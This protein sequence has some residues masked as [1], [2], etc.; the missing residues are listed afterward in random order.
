MRLA[1]RYRGAVRGYGGHTTLPS[2][3]MYRP[4]VLGG[5]VEGDSRVT[6]EDDM[7]DRRH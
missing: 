3:Q 4:E 2:V 5:W 1:V 6:L 7:D